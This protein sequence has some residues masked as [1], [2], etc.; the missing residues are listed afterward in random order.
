MMNQTQTCER[1]LTQKELVG[2]LE[3]EFGLSVSIRYISAVKAS[4]ANRGDVLFVANKARASE[5]HAWLR[6]NPRFR[7]NAPGI[8]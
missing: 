1:Y 5:V 6:A 4:A 2:A 8:G 7:V 3:S